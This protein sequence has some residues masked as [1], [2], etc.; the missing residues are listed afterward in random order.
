M[1][2]NCRRPRAGR[3]ETGH[4]RSL[5]ISGSLTRQQISS[6]TSK[7]IHRFVH[8][9][10]ILGGWG[11]VG[12]VDDGPTVDGPRRGVEL[13][14]M[15]FVDTSRPT[16]AFTDLPPSDVR[17]LETWV[18]L[19]AGTR[20]ETLNR[21]VVLMAHGNSG[22]P[23][24]FVM[25]AEL[26]AEHGV[27]VVAPVFPATNRYGDSAGFAIGDLY[28]QPEDLDFVRSSLR[29]EAASP[30]SVLHERLDVDRMIVLGH[31][32]GGATV[33]GWTRWGDAPQTDLL[34]TVLVAPAT[35]LNGP[36]G[37]GPHPEGPPVQLVHGEDDGTVPLV[38]SEEMFA[39][40]DGP[41]GLVVFPNVAHSDVIE[42]ETSGAYAT[43]EVV[44]GIVDEVLFDTSDAWSGALDA[45]A[46]GGARVEREGL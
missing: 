39:A 29:A 31:S 5:W 44:R 37:E 19:P 43:F 7:F 25:V 18:W 16:G 46:A 20:A 30:G 17:S 4:E 11:A 40:V 22:H 23:E 26:L 6:K 24:T 42:G 12:C 10:W 35:F 32:L 1:L 2:P 14:V 21:P 41:A 45:A 38:G 9:A 15:P 13:H 28:E 27:V 36:F 3:I 33:A 34:A 8:R